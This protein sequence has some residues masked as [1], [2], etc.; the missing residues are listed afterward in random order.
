MYLFHSTDHHRQ[1]DT[2]PHDVRTLVTE[3]ILLIIIMY[4]WPSA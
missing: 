2:E 1:E 3:V 4:I